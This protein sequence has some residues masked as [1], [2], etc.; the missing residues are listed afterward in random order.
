MSQVPWFVFVIVFVFVFVIVIVFV[1]VIFLARSSL[2]ITLIK[3]L[4]GH[5]FLGSLS[6]MVL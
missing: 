2:L 1:L 6:D 4:K 3:C 5:K